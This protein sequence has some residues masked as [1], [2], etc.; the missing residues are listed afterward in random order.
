MQEQTTL[1]LELN[2]QEIQLFENLL[3]AAAVHL[4]AK[5]SRGIAHFQNKLEAVINQFNKDSQ[6]AADAAKLAELLKAH[7]EK[8]VPETNE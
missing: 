8:N 7:D 6:E 5:G 2:Q 3:D 1:T 4:G